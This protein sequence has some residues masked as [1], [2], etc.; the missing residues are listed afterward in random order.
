MALSIN[1][2]SNNISFIKIT[3]CTFNFCLA[4]WLIA[5][6]IA[7]I[8]ITVSFGEHSL[9]FT[10]IQMKL[11]FIRQILLIFDVFTINQASIAVHFAFNE[12]S[13]VDSAVAIFF[14]TLSCDFTFAE[15]TG[16][17]GTISK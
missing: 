13:F 2:S 16:V 15:I 4:I 6:K 11:S 12:I 10:W 5:L 3:I 8:D 1:S 9:A 14:Q 7:G 17:F